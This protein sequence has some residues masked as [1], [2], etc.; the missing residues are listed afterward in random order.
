[1]LITDL[2]RILRFAR[3]THG[4]LHVLVGIC[5]IG[6]VAILPPN[7]QGRITALSILT[8]S[9]TSRASPASLR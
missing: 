9:P 6:G 4:N 2:E 8:R 1:M 7:D 3:E 5:D